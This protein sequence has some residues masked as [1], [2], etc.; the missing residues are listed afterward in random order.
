MSEDELDA[1]GGMLRNRLVRLDDAAFRRLNQS[2]RVHQKTEITHRTPLADI[3]VGDPLTVEFKRDGLSFELVQANHALISTLSLLCE[4]AKHFGHP[5]MTGE[6]LVLLDEP[7]LHL[8]PQKQATVI[9]GLAAESRA[10]GVQIISVTHSAHIISRVWS[11]PDS[12]L[13]SLEQRFASPK[14]RHTQADMLRTLSPTHDLLVYSAI[15]C[16]MS[17]RV[18]FVEG[19]SDKV[20]LEQCARAHFTGAA[21]RLE[22]FYRW[23]CIELHGAAN[24]PAT[25]LVD[26]LFSSP[27]LPQLD[28]NDAIMAA[29][30]LDRDYHRDPVHEICVGRQVRT[31][32]HVW[33]WH[34]IE[35]LFI[36]VD[37]LASLL[38]ASLGDAAPEDI[39]DRVQ[40]AIVAADTNQA[41]LENAEDM[42]GDVL[43][44]RRVKNAQAEARKL[45]RAAPEVWQR[46]HDREKFVLHHIRSSLHPSCKN[47]LRASIWDVVSAVPRVKLADVRVPREIAALLDEL[48]EYC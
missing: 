31:L 46:G 37:V 11:Q 38:H 2:L 15:N 21:D 39:R 24:E 7:E 14:Y 16:I 26:R 25:A 32:R 35:S 45:V 13:I 12:V 29:H 1:A 40:D 9:E 22:R 48:V 34:S 17:R 36:E 18:L 41:L 20:I 44:A 42:L 47:K 4:V 23:M 28:A 10:A 33:G 19:P 8:H 3:Q 27:W 5:T 6:R 30:V 43:R